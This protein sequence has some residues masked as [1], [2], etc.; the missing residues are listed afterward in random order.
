MK[1]KITATVTY[2][3]EIFPE[4]Y[5]DDGIIGEDAVI[6][7]EIQRMYDVPYESDL[8]FETCDNGQLS[9]IKIEKIEDADQAQEA[10]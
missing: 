3:T 2:E 8:V 7:Y 10:A 6:A 9:N 5:A 4:D 1:V